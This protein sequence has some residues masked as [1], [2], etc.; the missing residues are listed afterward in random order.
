MEDGKLRMEANFNRRGIAN[1]DERQ[2]TMDKN[3]NIPLEHF[4]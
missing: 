4:K 3:K 1:R 2:G